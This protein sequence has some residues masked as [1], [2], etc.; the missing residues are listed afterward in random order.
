MHKE[1][2]LSAGPGGQGQGQGGGHCRAPAGV[3]APDLALSRPPRGCTRGQV[4][5]EPCPP[6]DRLG[7]VDLCQVRGHGDTEEEKD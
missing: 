1:C 6:A 3:T 2:P 4:E 5:K 7:R